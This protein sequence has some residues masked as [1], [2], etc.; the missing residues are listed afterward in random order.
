MY[1]P[2][3][4]ASIFIMMYM[5]YTQHNTDKNHYINEVIQHRVQG[6]ERRATTATP[7]PFKRSGDEILPI[8]RNNHRELVAPSKLMGLT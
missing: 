6:F 5:V 2:L 4:Y 3:L 7:A 1:Q 8:P